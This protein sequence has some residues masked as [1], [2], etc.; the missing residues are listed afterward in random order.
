MPPR[1]NRARP[2]SDL[3][4]LLM[5][6]V[7]QAIGDFE[8]IVPGDRILVAV[9][10]GK[11]S[12]SLLRI[13]ELHR[14]RS[15][16]A[17]ELHALHLEGGWEPASA[18]RVEARVR[19]QGL[20]LE[21]ARRDIKACVQAHLRPGTNP[22]AFC[23]RL[24]RGFLYDLAH[25][26]GYHKI[27]LG[28]H[29]DD[30]AETLLLNL[31]FTGQVKSMAVDLT[32]DDGRNRVIRPLAYVEASLLRAYV[33][34]VGFEPVRVDCPHQARHQDPR[35]GMMRRIIE[36]LAV[37]Y[38]RVRR[39]LLASLKH[40]RPSHLLDLG[41]RQAWAHGEACSPGRGVL[42]SQAS[43]ADSTAGWSEDAEGAHRQ[44]AAGEEE[45]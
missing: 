43:A 6:R 24:R 18:E 30:L 32:A 39:S 34:E 45:D 4:H 29:L 20:E 14:R 44:V 13:L 5:R 38:P 3:E 10:G 37:P 9:S 31:F 33:Q 35:R 26:R 19:A 7:G 15:P 27:A 23:A 21:V 42:D 41:L 2:R 28:H 25:A 16:F 22:C 11:D 36:E 8:L 1:P 12:F 40:V 17:F